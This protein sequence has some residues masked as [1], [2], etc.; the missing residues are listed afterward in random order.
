MKPVTRVLVER[1]RRG[2]L[3]RNRNF[4]FFRRPETRGALR[5]H[6]FLRSIERDL[7]PEGQVRPAGEFEVAVEEDAE[8]DGVVL[9]IHL[10][11]LRTTRTA[12]L[13]RAEYAML[14]SHPELQKLLPPQG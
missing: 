10:L 14:L 2:L 1:L 7:M 12:F 8:R 6:H 5:I 11:H 3:S 4:Q 13:S 9:R